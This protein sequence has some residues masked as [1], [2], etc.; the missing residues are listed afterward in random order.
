MNEE[1]A[2]AVAKYT[3]RFVTS[4][5]DGVASWFA[6]T[7]DTTYT[8][9]EVAYRINHLISEI[10]GAHSVELRDILTPPKETE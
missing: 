4:A 9:R 2:K 1:E 8:G 5:L 10:N 7:P 3:Q 6:T